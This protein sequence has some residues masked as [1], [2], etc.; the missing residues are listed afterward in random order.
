[1]D[2]E[3]L[4]VIDWDLAA[5][6]AGNKKIAE[7]ILFLLLK[8]LPKDLAEILTAY[9][10][11]DYEELFFHVHKLHGAVAYCGLP[12]LKSVISSLETNLKNHIMDSLPS[13]LEQLET[14]VHLLLKEEFSFQTPLL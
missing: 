2:L 1:M 8:R 13:I 6:R 9:R 10:N 3:K 11:K 5:K 7:E 12:R 4:P 14:E